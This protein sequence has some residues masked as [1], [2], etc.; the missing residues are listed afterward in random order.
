MSCWR[1]FCALCLAMRAKRRNGSRA[2]EPQGVAMTAGIAEIREEAAVEHNQSDEEDEEADEMYIAQATMG[3]DIGES[4]END[5]MYVGMDHVATVEG[6]TDGGQ[7]TI[8]LSG[9]D[10]I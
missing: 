5:D 10:D 2:K 7:Q 8:T 6:K 3:V 1:L 4:D 9:G